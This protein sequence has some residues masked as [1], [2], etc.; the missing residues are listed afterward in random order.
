MS[1][2]DEQI[3]K[4]QADLEALKASQAAPDTSPPTTEPPID[5]SGMPGG[6]DS[7]PVSTSTTPEDPVGEKIV[8]EAE[9][10]VETEGL[11]I[12]N[13][14]KHSSISEVAGRLLDQDGLKS[15]V[16]AIGKLAGRVGL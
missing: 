5:T 10:A 8:R 9:Q 13:E 3:A 4:L 2:V 14:L 7:A 1:A 15:I 11:D 12:I 6:V 16:S